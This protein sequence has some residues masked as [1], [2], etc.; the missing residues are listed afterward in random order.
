MVKARDHQED[1]EDSRRARAVTVVASRAAEDMGASRRARVRTDRLV[2]DPQAV[3]VDRLE[4][5]V[6]EDHLA[7][8]DM[9]ASRRAPVTEANRAA[10]DMEASRRARVRTAVDPQVAMEEE[11]A[12]TAAS[13]AAEGMVEVAEAP[14][15]E[16]HQAATTATG[17]AQEDL[18]MAAA[19]AHRMAETT[20]IAR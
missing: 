12:V 8:E 19:A 15:T 4:V 6:M 7:A 3:M 20:K 16:D 14:H 11:V 18:V 2:V 5:R 9:E 17:E 13:R 10:E 1:T